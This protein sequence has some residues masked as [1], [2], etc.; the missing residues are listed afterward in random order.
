M[1][2]K[3]VFVLTSTVAS[4]LYSFV[5]K[6]M[7]GSDVRHSVLGLKMGLELAPYLLVALSVQA[8]LASRAATRV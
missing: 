6:V 5:Q 8:A 4:C 7:V 1:H 2:R 3:Q